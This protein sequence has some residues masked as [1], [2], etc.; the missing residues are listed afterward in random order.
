MRFGLQFLIFFTLLYNT[1]KKTDVVREWVQAAS[2]ARW[3]ISKTISSTDRFKPISS[4]RTAWTAKHVAVISAA[5]IQRL[6][7]TIRHHN[8]L[9]GRK[10]RLQN[11]SKSKSTLFFPN[12]CISYWPMFEIL[13]LP[14]SETTLCPKKRP[15]WSFSPNLRQ[16]LTDFQNFLLAYIMDN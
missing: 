7:Q 8:D 12:H 10:Y 2:V 6:R 1:N 13:S 16:I 9:H 5:R 3:K 4:A 15:T 14:H 11:A